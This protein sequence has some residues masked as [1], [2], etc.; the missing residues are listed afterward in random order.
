MAFAAVVY[1]VRENGGHMSSTFVISKTRVAPLKPLTNPWLEPLSAVFLAPLDITI[2]DSLSTQMELKEPR[3][4]TDWQVSLFWIKGTG[5]DWRPFVQNRVNEVGRLV[6]AEHWSHCP[7][8]GNP[9][10]L[11]SRGM[12][13]L[14]V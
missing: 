2:S 1:L 8:N 5:K 6:P 9:A 10:D 13:T 14:A 12:T 11:P 7:D 4:F 3:C